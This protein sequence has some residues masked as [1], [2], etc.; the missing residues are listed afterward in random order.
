MLFK[1]NWIDAF[2]IPTTDLTRM[3]TRPLKWLRFLCYIV[4]NSKG[5]LFPNKRSAEERGDEVDYNSTECRRRYYYRP[6]QWSLV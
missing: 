4:L 3:S 6:G 1:H 5:R 2:T